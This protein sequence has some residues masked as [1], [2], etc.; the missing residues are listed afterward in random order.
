MRTEAEIREELSEVR[1]LRREAIEA[2][3]EDSS[4]VLYSAQQALGWV[5]GELKS[6]SDLGMLLREVA[7]YSLND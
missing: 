2:C 5:L 4:A 6:P 3:D 1:R 7:G